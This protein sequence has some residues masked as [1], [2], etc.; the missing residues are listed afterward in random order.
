MPNVMA[1]LPNAGD[2]L[3]STPQSF[4]DTHY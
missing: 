4:A 2:A 1:T 3:C